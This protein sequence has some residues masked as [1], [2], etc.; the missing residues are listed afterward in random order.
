MIAAIQILIA[1][2]SANAFAATKK[3][4]E[5]IER[6]KQLEAKVEKLSAAKSNP[7]LNVGAT[8]IDNKVAANNVDKQDANNSNNFGAKNQI[9]TLLENAQINGLIQVEGKWFN[10]KNTDDT[11]QDGADIR[12][13]RL[14]ITGNATKDIVYRFQNDFGAKVITDAF[15]AYQGIKNTEFKLGNFKPSF[16]LEKLISVASITFVERSIITASTP[17]RLVG[18]QVARFGDDWQAAFGIFGDAIKANDDKQTTDDDSTYSVSARFSYAPI[19]NEDALLHLGLSGSHFGKDRNTKVGTAGNV[20]ADPIDHKSYVDFEFA[21]KIKSV[22]FQSE[23]ILNRVNYDNDAKGTGAIATT[24]T[25]GNFDGFYFQT[26]WFLTG[27]QKQYRVQTGDFGTV[28]VKNPY[29]KGG[30]GAWELAAR[31]SSLDQ[32]DTY[33]GT[34]ITLGK[35]QDFTV[36]INWYLDENTRLMLNYQKSTTDVRQAYDQRFN[37]VSL[38]AQLSF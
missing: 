29:D 5:L 1:N 35:T 10:E 33:R 9:T 27:D 28:K 23:Y 38:R 16:S 26:S 36:A 12:R 3:E 18:A 31:F 24:G 37:A 2:Y 21:G 8:K 20:S 25:K 7:P 17:P 30:I 4:Q 32:N 19:N 15:L 22:Y 6:L 14:S 13:L 11:K 34:N